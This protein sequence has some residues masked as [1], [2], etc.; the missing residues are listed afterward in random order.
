VKRPQ[1]R[2]GFWG[3]AAFEPYIERVDGRTLFANRLQPGAAL[4]GGHRPGKLLQSK[5]ADGR[6]WR[7]ARVSDAITRASDLAAAR[8][9]LPCN[10]LLV[11][12]MA[13]EDARAA[14]RRGARSA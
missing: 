4:H 8:K 6:S 5:R 11:H 2:D 12:V 10:A 3:W 1:D 14:A 9:W 7:S 13:C